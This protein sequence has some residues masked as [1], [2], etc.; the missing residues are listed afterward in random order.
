MFGIFHTDT[1]IWICQCCGFRAWI[2]SKP[3]DDEEYRCPLCD[4][5]AKA[6]SVRTPTDEE[7]EKQEE[8]LRKWSKS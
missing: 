7:I 4:H 6:A 5:I 8:Q 3:M 2:T 1:T